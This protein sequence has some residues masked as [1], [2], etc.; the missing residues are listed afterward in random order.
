MIRP[1]CC[2]DHRASPHVGTAPERAPQVQRNASSIASSVSSATGAWLLA[3]AGVVDEDV[4][5]AERR[6]GSSI[7]RSQSA[8]C[9]TSAW[10]KATSRPPSISAMA[11]D[12]FALAP[13]AD[14]HLRAFGEERLGDRPAD[15]AR[16]TGD[17]G[18]ATLEISHSPTPF[19]RLLRASAVPQD[20]RRKLSQRNYRMNT[21]TTNRATPSVR[22]SPPR[23]ARRPTADPTSGA[24][25]SSDRHRRQPCRR[26]W[27]AARR[28]RTRI[29]PGSCT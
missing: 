20:P 12:P 28:R 19:V 6:D 9:L 17:D 29:G 27:R 13:T 16:A 26:P 7:A 22:R 18:D 11:C 25:R 15:A 23:R 10:T 4:E 5:L 24:R 1:H 2:G 3:P 21:E 14:D 8:R